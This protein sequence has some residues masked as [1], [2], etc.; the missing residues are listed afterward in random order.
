MDGDVDIA[1]AV[2][3]A[4]GVAVLCAIPISLNR[5]RRD[6]NANSA[7]INAVCAAV[8]ASLAKFLILILCLNCIF[9]LDLLL[10]VI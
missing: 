5:S 4:A 2:A 6:D 7:S 10:L 3:I 9:E 1:T 8:L